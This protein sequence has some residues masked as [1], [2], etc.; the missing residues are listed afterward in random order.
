[1]FPNIPV[2]KK[3]DR[4][5]TY[6]RGDF[7]RDEMEERAPGTESEGS[8]YTWTTRRPTTARS[9]PSTGTWP[10]RCGRTPTAC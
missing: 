4:Y 3:S 9:T 5:Y 2:Q 10:T 1:V 8:G 7:N 6:D